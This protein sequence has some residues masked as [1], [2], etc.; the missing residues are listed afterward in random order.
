LN[1]GAWVRFA[2]DQDVRQHPTLRQVAWEAIH[3]AFDIAARA[4]WI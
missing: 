1:E 4:P 2:L 3:E